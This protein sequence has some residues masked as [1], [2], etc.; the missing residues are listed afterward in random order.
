MFSRLARRYGR[1]TSPARAGSR[2]LAANPM[3]VVVNA[4]TNR[5]GPIGARS[6]QARHDEREDQQSAVGTARFGPD[7]PQIGVSESESEQPEGEQ[8]NEYGAN[9]WPHA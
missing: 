2:K 3:A 6:D 7:A 8:Q 9:A 1:I 4:L 5:V